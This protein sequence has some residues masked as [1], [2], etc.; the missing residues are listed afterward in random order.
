MENDTSQGKF[1]FENLFKGRIG[2]KHWIIGF[3][4]LIGS[5]AL[6]LLYA[7]LNPESTSDLEGIS[8]VILVPL[9]LFL[10]S[11]HIRRLHDLNQSGWLSL[12]S[13]VPLI[14]IILFLVL[15]ISPGK[16]DDNKYGKKIDSKTSLLNI[17]LP[18]DQV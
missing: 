14:N 3:S 10:L 5:W 11:F 17:F 18:S 2:R 8:Y 6:F 16:E 1:K 9:W 4:I 13:F 15:A 7:F 12:L